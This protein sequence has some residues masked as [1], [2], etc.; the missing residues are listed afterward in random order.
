MSQPTV[1][2]S[3]LM[4]FDKLETKPIITVCPMVTL[5]MQALIQYGYEEELEL[6]KGKS[7]IG[8]TMQIFL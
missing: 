1:D 6:M 8:L 5:N 2:S 4:P 7:E 3:Y